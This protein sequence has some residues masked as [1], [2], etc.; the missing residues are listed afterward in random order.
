MFAC[1]RETVDGKVTEAGARAILPK[2][3]EPGSAGLDLYSAEEVTILPHTQQTVSTGWTMALPPGT[4]GRIA[5]RSGWAFK[6]MVDV[7]AGVVDVSYRGTV[8]VILMNHSKDAVHVRV[9]DRMAQ[10]VL[11]QVAMMDA[12]ET[13]DELSA[14]QRGQGG[15][16]STGK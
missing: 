8:K 13:K 1:K 2:R 4:Y 16:G 7:H 15:F 5:P 11:E 9:G 3:Q 6:F 14:T 10:L 12:I